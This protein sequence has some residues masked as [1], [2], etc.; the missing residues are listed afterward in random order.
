L[1]FALPRH[2]CPF[3]AAFCTFGFCLPLSCSPTFLYLHLE[4]SYRLVFCTVDMPRGRKPAAQKATSQPSPSE[5]LEKLAVDAPTK[6]AHTANDDS[7]RVS[8]SPKRQMTAT[9]DSHTLG[10][11]ATVAALQ[12]ALFALKD[13]VA[14][15]KSNLTEHDIRLRAVESQPNTDNHPP[16]PAVSVDTIQVQQP[17]P[18][19]QEPARPDKSDVV[20]TSDKA[21]PRP[22]TDS[23][24]AAF[25]ATRDTLRAIS[26]NQKEHRRWNEY[27][28]WTSS[29][30]SHWDD[31]L[32][33]GLEGAITAFC[34]AAFANSRPL[35]SIDT[36]T[37]TWVASWAPG[38]REQLKGN[39]PAECE[40]FFKACL[41]HLLD[42]ELFSNQAAEKWKD[43]P[44]TALGHLL[45]E[46]QRKLSQQTGHGAFCKQPSNPAVMV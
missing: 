13:E 46:V 5:S 26:S 28:L 15:L 40:A 8:S 7:S 21:K 33:P 11:D 35:K 41:W 3:S 34:M 27:L 22:F 37:A 32:F 30:I 6:R 44:W 1:L 12:S 10:R 4:L 23:E 43:G 9:P 38:F 17:E 20:T 19:I 39:L 18:N 2:K 45:S 16:P 36:D 42:E 24:A 31:A 14:G 29:S 25:W